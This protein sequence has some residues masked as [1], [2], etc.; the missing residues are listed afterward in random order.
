VVDSLDQEHKFAYFG[1]D[2][3]FQSIYLKDGG[4]FCFFK[5]HL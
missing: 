2:Q 1:T 4:N 3:H 5:F